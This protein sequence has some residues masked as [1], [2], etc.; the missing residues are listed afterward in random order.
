MSDHGGVFESIADPFL[1]TCPCSFTNV[2][3]LSPPE[4]PCKCE[5][6]RSRARQLCDQEWPASDGGEGHEGPPL[7]S[8]RHGTAEHAHSATHVP[9]IELCSASLTELRSTD[10]SRRVQSSRARIAL[11]SPRTCAA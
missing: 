10:Q 5:A 1:H 11:G 2:V 7:R 8:E 3:A 6:T 4:Q 9:D